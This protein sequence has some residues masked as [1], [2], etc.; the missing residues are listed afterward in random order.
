MYMYA[1]IIYYVYIIIHKYVLYIR[2]T[3][4]HVTV[5]NVDVCTKHVRTCTY[6]HVRILYSP[7]AIILVFSETPTHT[8][9]L[10][11]NYPDVPT[12]TLHYYRMLTYTV[13]TCTYV[14]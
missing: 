8:P 11:C 14:L 13:H 10:Q 4:V 3:Y 12:T 1:R 5:Y 2:H 7:T 6:M 9:N